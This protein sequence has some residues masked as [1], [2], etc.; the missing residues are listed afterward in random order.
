[1]AATYDLA[2]A[3]NRPLPD[4]PVTRADVQKVLE[5]GYVILSDLFSASELA[6]ARGEV[7]RLAG[8]EP[9]RGRNQ[10]EGHST[11]RIYS[12]LN[13]SRSPLHGSANLTRAGP[14]P[15]IPCVPTRVS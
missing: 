8:M 9:K 1:M 7:R 4:D 5:Q 14:E 11:V 12:L 2:R 6:V 10:F 15:L 13:K 3:L